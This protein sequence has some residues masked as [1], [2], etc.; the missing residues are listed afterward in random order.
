MEPAGV[1]REA[2]PKVPGD[3]TGELYTDSFTVRAVP[4]D[5]RP[6][7]PKGFPL[8]VLDNVVA[9][10]PSAFRYAYRGAARWCLGQQD[11][12]FDDLDQAVE[13]DPDYVPAYVIRGIMWMNM[14]GPYTPYEDLELTTKADPRWPRSEVVS[15]I[16]PRVAE[17]DASE[18]F[19]T[20]LELDPT[21]C[22]PS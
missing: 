5:P 16:G 17:S 13:L 7:A 4:S 2:S 1:G 22:R 20:A 14:D 21:T 6:N 11:E 12:A 8:Q 18:D 9:E 19:V 3:A 15:R 10:E